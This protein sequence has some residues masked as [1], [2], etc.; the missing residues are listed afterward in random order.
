MPDHQ[1]G[2]DAFLEML[3][4]FVWFVLV[5][6]FVSATGNVKAGR[7]GASSSSENDDAHRLVVL[8][9]AQNMTQVGQHLT[10]NGI[11]LFRA[12]QGN[13]SNT[14]PLLE[15]N[16][17]I[18]HATA[19]STAGNGRGQRYLP[20]LARTA[21]IIGSS[22]SAEQATRLTCS[23]FLHTMETSKPVCGCGTARRAAELYR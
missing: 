19:P 12:V 10:T 5:G 3:A 14:I 16:G 4:P 22:S 6:L 18:G 7:K 20:C 2:I 9:G 8:N 11:E 1:E 13:V 15:K 17:L 23:T 21:G